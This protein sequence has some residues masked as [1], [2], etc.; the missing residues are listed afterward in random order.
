MD[1]RE[2]FRGPFVTSARDRQRRISELIETCDATALRFVASELH[3]MSGEAGM[4]DF[5]RVADLARIAER[6]ALAGDRARLQ[7][8]LNDLSEEI[9]V[10]ERGAAN[11]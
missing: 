3:C 7:D 6:E 1:L 11:E 10:V 8:L 2:S 9:A 4:L 5:G